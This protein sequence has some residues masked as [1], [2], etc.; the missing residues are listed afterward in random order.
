M[1]KKSDDEVRTLLENASRLISRGEL[2]AAAR[3]LNEA[4]KRAPSDPRVSMLGG[5]MAEKAGNPVGAVELFHRSLTVSPGWPPAM[6]SL[7]TLYG[8]MNQFP[9]AMEWA[10]RVFTAASNNLAL[11]AGVIDIA[12]RAGDTSSAIRYLRH[13]LSLV[14]KD[15]QLTELLARDLAAVDEHEEALELWGQIL[16]WAPESVVAQVGRAQS[17]MALKR[18]EAEAAVMALLDQD[19][20]NDLYI[21]F[22][23]MLKGQ[24]PARLPQ[25]L[26]KDLF[27]RLAPVY[28]AH[29]VRAMGYRLPK[30]VAERLLSE[31]PDRKLNVL[32]LG[33]GTGLLGVCLGR[34]DG[35]LVGV[36]LSPAMIEQASIHG[37]YDRFHQV[38]LHDA[39]SETADCLFDVLAALDVFIYAGE[40]DKAVPDACR[41]LVPGGTLVFSCEEAPADGPDMILQPS[42][43]FAHRRAHVEAVCRGAG[44]AEVSIEDTVLRTENGLPV[45]G[46]V[47]WARKAAKKA[48]RR[49]TRGKA[50][51]AAEDQPQQ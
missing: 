45:Q 49:S 22:M 37:V 21:H 25:A 3:C 13:G 48:V 2:Q 7:A 30:D 28:D 38:D 27:E 4:G 36:D 18:P 16:E 26:N 35:G 42:D 5:L 32:D 6:I 15:P 10:E 39:L 47:V 19:P 8:Q 41:I 46:F 23:S 17:L 12:H 31:H 33:C 24:A 51:A 20:N 11:L 9:Q 50:K 43:R 44:F 1:V 14:P 29:V 40:L 34:L